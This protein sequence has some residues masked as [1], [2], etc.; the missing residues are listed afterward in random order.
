MDV[1]QRPWMQINVTYSVEDACYYGWRT[2]CIYVFAEVPQ[3]RNSILLYSLSP[4]NRFGANQNYRLRKNLKKHVHNKKYYVYWN[5]ISWNKSDELE[6]RS[7]MTQRNYF[8]YT[9]LPPRASERKT[10]F[11]E[12][13]THFHEKSK[14]KTF[15]ETFLG[16]NSTIK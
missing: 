4:K 2:P 14:S 11:L 15:V 6:L 7:P 5:K 3:M 9:H 16:V 10:K 1:K 8:I 12:S 13:K